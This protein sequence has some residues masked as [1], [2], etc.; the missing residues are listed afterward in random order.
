MS[1]SAS[2]SACAAAA[3]LAAFLG[4]LAPAGASAATAADSYPN[5]PVRMIVP[6]GTGAATDI[7]ARVLAQKL[8]ELWG[9]S[10]VVDNRPGSGGVLGTDAA[11]K[12][13]PDG[14]TLLVYGINQTITP[15]IY[16]KLPYDH[17]RDF[18]LTSLY[19]TMPNMLV[20]HPAVAA[21]TLPEF[22]NLLRSAPGKYRYASSGLGASPHLTM[23]LYKSVAKVDILHVPYK[24]AAQAYVDLASGQ[25]HA[26]F[27]N[28]PGALMNVR[29]GRLRGIA[30]TSA[31]RAEQIPEVPTVIE[32]GIPDFEVTV[33]QGIALPAATPQP[34]V[35][36]VHATMMKALNA[37]DLRQRFFDQGVA[38]AP[39]SRAEFAA[40][41]KK[42]TARW[43]RVVKEAGVTPD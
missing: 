18:A 36:R 17:L 23:E 25:V 15:A 19:A 32:S 22:T 29:A 33:W 38:A 31:K 20:V 5:K 39:I 2:R 43:A 12:S 28:L 4:L 37:P 34:I 8:A 30:V 3:A 21:K 35:D 13:N 26:M 9:Q 14:Y 1:H 11:A 24:S 41:V 27:S 40:Y 16:K 6:F 7:V 10:V 42:E